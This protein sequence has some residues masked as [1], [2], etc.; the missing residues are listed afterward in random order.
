MTLAEMTDMTLLR[1]GVSSSDT[2][3]RNYIRSLINTEYIRL[4]AEENLYEKVGTLSLVAGSSV[5]DMPND[6]QRTIQITEGGHALRPVTALEYTEALVSPG[7]HRVYMQES[8]ERILVA[9]E[10]TE[11]DSDGLRIIYVARPLELDTDASVPV[12]LPVEYHDLLVELALMRA[13][14]AEE[15]ATLSQGA[16]MNAQGLLDRLRAHRTMSAG[17]GIGKMILPPV[18]ARYG[19]AWR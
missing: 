16:Q 19:R 7:R 9:P 4:A 8:P 12:A 11:S 5:V 10:P 13:F 3:M 15:D 17:N 18:A 2:Q 6:W 1:L 14:L